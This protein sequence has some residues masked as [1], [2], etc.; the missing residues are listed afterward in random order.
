MSNRRR[1][2]VTYRPSKS[3]A[4]FGGI[5]GGIFILIG[6]FVAI[7]TF[8]AFGVLWTLIAVAITGINLYQGFGKGYVGPEIHIEEE[9]VENS[10]LPDGGRAN[11]AGP[12]PQKRL[13]QLETLKKAGLV[14]QEEYSQKRKEILEEL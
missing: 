13:E 2:R 11:A 6:L 1:K 8:G 9:N 10:D 7:P 4:A 12:D 3:N 5:V 14:T